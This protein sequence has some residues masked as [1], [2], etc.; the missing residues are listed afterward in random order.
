MLFAKK[1]DMIRRLVVT[2]SFLLG[3]SPIFPAVEHAWD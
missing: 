1:L 2:V 3:V